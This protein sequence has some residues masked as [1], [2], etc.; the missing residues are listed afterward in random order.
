M[1]NILVLKSSLQP[2]NFSQT[3]WLLNQA[4]Q[5]IVSAV[6]DYNPPHKYSPFTYQYINLDKFNLIYQKFTP[7]ILE[8]FNQQLILTNTDTKED[9]TSKVQEFLQEQGLNNLVDVVAA[10]GRTLDLNLTDFTKQTLAEFSLFYD[11]LLE[12]DPAKV[13]L[14]V[15]DV[16]AL[17]FNYTYG[18]VQI[19]DQFNP[20]RLSTRRLF[21]N[22]FNELNWFSE[23]A[24]SGLQQEFN[25]YYVSK[26]FKPFY[27]ANLL[28]I[29]KSTN[30]ERFSY[31]PQQ[32]LQMYFELLNAGREPQGVE[33]T[34][35][36][37][38]H[39]NYTLSQEKHHLNALFDPS[40]SD[41][42]FN[43]IYHKLLTRAR[44]PTYNHP[45]DE[46]LEQHVDFSFNRTASEALASKVYAIG[47]Y[48]Y[49]VNSALSR[50]FPETNPSLALAQAN[51]LVNEFLQA[52]IIVIACPIYNHTIPTKLKNYL[53]FWVRSGVTFNT[54]NPQEFISRNFPV[55]KRLFVLSAAG[56]NDYYKTTLTDFFT[57]FASFIGAKLQPVV[58]RPYSAFVPC[59]Y[60][61]PE[62][63]QEQEQIAQQT[64]E[65]LENIC[66]QGVSEY[67]EERNT[68][69]ATSLKGNLSFSRQISLVNTLGPQL[70][71]LLDPTKLPFTVTNNEAD[72]NSPQAI[73]AKLAHCVPENLNDFSGIYL[74]GTYFRQCTPKEEQGQDILQSQPDLVMHLS[75]ASVDYIHYCLEQE[76]A[77]RSYNKVRDLASI[78]PQSAQLCASNWLRASSYPVDVLTAQDYERVIFFA[79]LNQYPVPEFEGSQLLAALQHQAT[80]FKVNQ[81][82]AKAHK[83]VQAYAL[84]EETSTEE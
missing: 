12:R 70:I 58:Y 20:I 50:D 44:L 78:T 38:V 74:W 41:T 84:E 34:P 49:K 42:A 63:N 61:E 36:Q 2:N 75:K 16:D 79:S 19:A 48:Q 25:E 28:P 69:L 27:Q 17:P 21:A 68:Y 26:I 37:E 62:V 56:A 65:D 7:Y 18:H 71:P 77:L 72:G 60:L 14:L 73:A 57:N 51:N 23:Q 13:K 35:A 39:G 43:Q 15:R 3:D 33:N 76:Q 80:F 59:P 4:L 30:L 5:T 83:Y 24:T 32:D 29:V 8:K 10:Q 22:K 9:F 67:L 53:D 45:W 52:D 66:Y 1:L 46:I 54:D 31:T 47:I 64:L 40:V 11:Q 55:A 6:E 81:G 82:T